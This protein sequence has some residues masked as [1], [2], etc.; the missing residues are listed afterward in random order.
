MTQTITKINRKPGVNK[1]GESYVK[2][3]LQLSSRGDTWINGF[4]KPWT[5]HWDK[6]TE[7]TEKQI[8]VYDD[9]KWGWQ[10][11]A[12]KPDKI[13]DNELTVALETRMAA[14][15]ERMDK[16]AAYLKEKA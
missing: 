12:L 6:G 1:K 7:L 13:I 8:E 10:F 16:M 15:E 11:K 3:G 4:E 14:L 9:E 5:Q 2:I